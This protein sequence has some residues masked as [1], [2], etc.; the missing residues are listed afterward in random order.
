V[1]ASGPLAMP[2]EPEVAQTDVGVF[3]FV[4]AAFYGSILAVALFWSVFRWSRIRWQASLPANPARRAM[5]DPVIELAEERWAKRV[6]GVTTPPRAP[7]TRYSNAPI[8][9]NFQMQLRAIHK[10]VVEWRRRENDWPESARAL[11][12]GESDDWL[13]GLDEFCSLVG[14]Y[15]RWVIKAGAKD[16]FPKPDVLQENED[17]N[18][19]WSRLVLYFAEYHWAL[20]TLLRAHA[21]ATPE[22]AR[23]E[24]NAQI[25]LLLNAMGLR[26]RRE[27]FDARI[28]FNAPSNPEA[29][30]LLILQ[31]P[32]MT[33]DRVVDEAAR[34]LRI[35]GRHIVR[36][37]RNYHQFKQREQPYPLHPFLIE[38]AKV[39][40]HFLLMG[41][42]ALIFYNHYTVGDSS[43][44]RYVWEHVLLA[45]A[46]V[47]EFRACGLTLAFG[48]ALTVTAHWVRIYRWEAAMLRRATPEFPLDR[49]LTALVPGTS[50]VLPLPRPGPWWNPNLYEPAAW[51]LRAI[52]FLWL[53]IL[54]L[55]LPAPSFVTFLVVK[56]IFAMLA[57]A[58]MASII[59]PATF[60]WISKF[61]QD[62]VSAHPHAGPG[63]RLLNQLN[64]TATRPTSL[65]WQSIRYHFRPSAP[66]G[67]PLGMTQGVVFYFSL[68]ALF[69]GAGVFLCQEMLPLWFTEQYRAGADLK[70]LA[71]GALFW[72]TMY[73][74]RY[75]LFLLVAGA[76]AGLAAFPIKGIAALLAVACL[77]GPL[78][79][80]FHGE[81][82][83]A[84]LTAAWPIA[85]FALTAMFLETPLIRLLRVARARRDRKINNTAAIAANRAPAPERKP[86]LAVVY[87]S[88]D[89]LSA[90]SLTPE[91]LLSRWR[92]LRDRLDSSGVR[93]LDRLLRCP[94]DA[95][96]LQ[97]FETL[98][99]TEQRHDVTLWHPCQL[100]VRDQ[101]A[102]LS[103]ALGLNLVV[104]APAEREQ[105]LVA[106]Q[107]RRWL[108]TM[109]STSGHSQDTAINLVDIALRLDRDGL[110]GQTVFY[111]IQ[112]KFD[113]GTGNRPAQTPYDQG[114]LGQREK[115]ARLICALAPA[116]HAYSLQDWTPFGFKAGGLTG[117]DL[118]PEEALHLTAMLLLD[119]NA[120]V[121]DLDGLIADVRE[122]L[123]DPNLVV[124]IP[125]R[126]TTNTRTP[127]GQA[128][129]MVEEGHR[130]FLRGLVRVLGGDSSECLGTGWGN[131]MAYGYGEVQRALL[132]IETPLMPLTS[133]MHRGTSF[134]LRLEG[135]IGFGPHAVGISEDT[136]AV[137]QATH[138]AVAFGR[139]VRF[140]TSKALWH[141]IRETWSHA[142]WLNSFP[143][144]SGGYFQMMHDPLMQ[145]INDFGPLSVFARDLRA[146]SGRFYL[147][148]LVT[149]LNIL[150]L[151]LA[152]ILDVTPFVQIL[153]LLWNV[154]FIINQVLTVHSLQACL[155]SA[156]FHRIPALG[157]A[158]IA[159]GAATAVPSLHS[160]APG[161]AVLGFLGGG[162]VVGLGRWLATRLR[163]V[164]LFG[165]QLV[166]HALG[167]CVRQSL[168]FAMSGASP[169]DA[170][171]V[172]MAFRAWV[173]PREDRPLARFPGPINLKVVVWGV[174]LV[175]LLLNLIALSRLD[176]LNVLML[177]PSLLF[178]V[179][180]LAGPYLM[181]PLRGKNLGG[182]ELPIKT[183]GWLGAFLLY[184]LISRLLNHSGGRAWLGVI[185]LSVPFILI[186]RHALRYATYRPALSRARHRLTTLLGALG[187]RQ[188]QAKHTAERLMQMT[189]DGP[190]AIEAEFQRSA[191]SPSGHIAVRTWIDT[192]LRPLLRA[193][194]TH[195]DGAHVLNS[196]WIS[197]FSRSFVLAWFVL[198]WFFLVPVP[199]LFVVSAGAYRIP[200][201][202]GS[203]LMLLGIV[204]GGAMALAGIGELWRRW[205]H[206]R[207]A[208]RGLTLT[209]E[210]TFAHFEEIARHPS[211]LTREQLAELHGLFIDTLLY[212]DQRA[213]AYARRC[214]GQIQN[215]LDDSL[216]GQ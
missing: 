145:R 13:N 188:S 125:G 47:P 209:L 191:L 88:G 85:G 199:G 99:A 70:L 94:S 62:W 153:I 146:C 202:P 123:A 109:M 136:W 152:I 169:N 164:V 189:L 140:A 195:L 185:L 95:T 14:L 96:L 181:T 55:R 117:M 2:A 64:L 43:V 90:G 101:P 21:A 203:M 159:A 156:G 23:T 79:A 176:L 30:D 51:T 132:N 192:R 113:S 211:R 61:L 163:D 59:L 5:S 175:S 27:S 103:P 68:A 8:E 149:L 154:G 166:L 150:L 170:H 172:N 198:L 208:R 41:I 133:R 46:F 126:S 20:L 32:G 210:R 147:S 52:G 143:R 49:A 16:G 196:R 10:L 92:V 28:L 142:E 134:R 179:S 11:V 162:F 139:R 119:R 122:A 201:W 48:L 86:R 165:P 197:V 37:I 206:R 26:Q 161:F 80:P 84:W 141:K 205:V 75:G 174:G 98:H 89:A 111:L 24:I 212:L 78:L 12:E 22:R 18:H 63:V 116:A 40:P 112:N 121:H 72:C 81:D 82:T 44:V 102:L 157:G 114:E 9:Q 118:V 182:L 58:E 45:F 54:L 183:A 216:A 105:L 155:E 129:Q 6:L 17:G 74:L 190:A 36:F 213:D 19:I 180:V 107:A 71:G 38:S 127:I 186:A 128:S 57:F 148:A 178:S 204:V 66:S 15:M 31:Q 215:R 171:G 194:V 207:H 50:L 120:T 67:T 144:W 138:N 130:A 7:H 135:L 34:R 53:G 106:W 91:L 65:L 42:G 115:L 100:V 137:S 160:L 87:M 110:A 177:L 39:L 187:L 151:P 4:T 33:L 1:P 93:C 3:L 35:P 104:A 83:R 193:P 25:T 173:G 108:A 168:E 29:F 167:Q 158:A 56:G 124:V 60:S 73:L 200:N 76:A 77:A 184:V 69:F 214:L 131:L 97:A